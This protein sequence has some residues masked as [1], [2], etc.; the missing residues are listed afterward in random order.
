MDYYLRSSNCITLPCCES[1]W[2]NFRAILALSF[3][4][5]H[6]G[7]NINLEYNINLASP[8]FCSKLRRFKIVT[9]K[10]L[11]QNGVRL[12]AR[13]AE[14]G[15]NLSTVQFVYTYS[16]SLYSQLWDG[17]TVP[18]SSRKAE[19]MPVFTTVSRRHYSS[20][21]SCRLLCY[22]LLMSPPTIFHST[23]I[24]RLLRSDFCSKIEV[25]C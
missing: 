9:L 22:R 11:K 5:L 10:F 19:N 2:L 8:T 25:S 12:F 13:L 20:R 4:V 17:L 7:Y 23:L 3:S 6:I 16:N 24:I 15:P 18:H 1:V 14:I 21:E